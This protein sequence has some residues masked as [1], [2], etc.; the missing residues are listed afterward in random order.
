MYYKIHLKYIDSQSHLNNL[1]HN[2]NNITNLPHNY[3]FQDY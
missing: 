2:N 3:Y 1:L